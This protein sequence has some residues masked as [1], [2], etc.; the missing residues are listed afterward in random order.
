MLEKFSERNSVAQEI[1]KWGTEEAELEERLKGIDDTDVE[2]WRS[3][4]D[5]AG[6]KLGELQRDRGRAESE[7]R[8]QKEQR[9][10]V[11]R[12]LTVAAA[13]Q[14]AAQLQSTKLAVASDAREVL[15]ATLEI[16][17]TREVDAVSTLMNEIFLGMI[18]AGVEERSLIR[19]AAITREFQITVAGMNDR[20]LDPSQDLNGASRRALT[21]AFVLALAEVSG[22]SAPN[23]IDTPLG[24][25]SGYVKREVLKT[26]SARSSQ[27]ILFLTH[28]E[29]AGCEDILDECAGQVLTITNPAHYPKILMHDP[30]LVGAGVLVCK[31]N[32]R[33]TCRVCERRESNNSVPPAAVAS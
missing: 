4:R 29:I 14:H 20:V 1:E 16:M 13:L 22:R 6:A 9:E 26:A 32:H 5:T 21:L 8:A 3:Q 2:L 17:R 30:G 25:M 23:V 11:A 31:C 10:R 33:A 18:G 7:L 27:L 28:S 15:E 24:M 12:E 19:K